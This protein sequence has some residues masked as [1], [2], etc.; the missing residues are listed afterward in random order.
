MTPGPVDLARVSPDLA[1]LLVPLESLQEDPNNARVHPEENIAAIRASLAEFGQTI[2]LVVRRSDGRILSGNGRFSVMLA[3][4][5]RFAAVVYTDDDEALGAAFSRTDNRTAE[6]AAWDDARLA[7]ALASLS[8]EHLAATGFS[9]KRL[10]ELL[11]IASKTVRPPEPP[12][13][14]ARFAGD[15]ETAHTCPECGYEWS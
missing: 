12:K 5:W 15:L 14:F 9:G 4:G 13:E 1:P 8:K 10:D 7:N 6:L 2:P 11:A 3:D